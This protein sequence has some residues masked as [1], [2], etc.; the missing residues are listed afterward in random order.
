MK[1]R[2]LKPFEQIIAAGTHREQIVRICG[3]TDRL[4]ELKKMTIPEL[5]EVIKDPDMQLT[6]RRQ[7]ERTLRKILSMASQ[8]P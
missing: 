7:A 1:Q 8:Q 6:V 4:A 2:K 3:V 5:R